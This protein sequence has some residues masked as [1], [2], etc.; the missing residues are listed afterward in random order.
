MSSNTSG[1]NGFRVADLRRSTAVALVSLALLAGSLPPAG[2]SPE[3]SP[4]APG[5]TV[6]P[7]A[8]AATQERQGSPRPVREAVP[9]VLPKAP[10]TPAPK[11]PVASTQLPV[12][13]FARN[14][15]TG[16]QEIVVPDVKRT[17]VLI[18]DSQSAAPETWPQLALRNLGYSVSFAGAGGTGFVTPNE[19]GARNYYDS[20]TSGTW[21][22]PHGDPAL[23]VLEGGGNDAGSGASDEE[24]LANANG[25]ILAMQRTYPNSRMVLIGTLSRSAVDGGGRRAE[26]D[27]L[28]DGLAEARGVPFVSAGH[29]LTTYRLDGLLADTVHLG[30]SGHQRAANI[31]ES[32]LAG[33]KLG[34]EHTTV[35]PST[36]WTPYTCPLE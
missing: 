36:R 17:A 19:E 31:L 21:T 33:L 29:W 30:S 11:A 7:S 23:I 25:L 22:L 2:A 6:V 13:S 14:P 16:R 28:L 10:V 35:D 32:E 1:S 12:G 20:L 8:L 4:M 3:I 26:V 15:S 9:G 34:V 5:N 24:I 27:A 18:G